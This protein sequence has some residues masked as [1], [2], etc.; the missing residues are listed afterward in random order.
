MFRRFLSTPNE[1]GPQT[2][3]IGSSMKLSF[4]P[5]KEHP[6]R[7]PCA[8]WAS[9][10]V[11]AAP[12]LRDG[13]NLS[14]FGPPPWRLEPNQPRA[15]FM[16]WTPLLDSSL[17][18]PCTNHGRMHGC[19]ALIILPFLKK[20]RPRRRVCLKVILHKTKES[21]VAKTKGTKII[22]KRDVTM[23]QTVE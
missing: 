1:F 13:L 22:M 14:F 11:R 18:M 12:R 9:I 6:K 17:L 5:Y 4:H 16:T 20:S 21:G 3:A 23:F 2:N 15:S 10:L 19:H 7:T 8:A